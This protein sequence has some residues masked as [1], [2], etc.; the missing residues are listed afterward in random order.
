MGLKGAFTF[1]GLMLV[2]WVMK[3]KVLNVVILAETKNYI[4]ARL[5]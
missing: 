2:A 4:S 1:S 3:V 5:N